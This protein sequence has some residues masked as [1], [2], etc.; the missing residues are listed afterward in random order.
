MP[1][2][3][4]GSGSCSADWSTVSVRQT[5]IRARISSITS[6]PGPSLCWIFRLD[7]VTHQTLQPLSHLPCHHQENL[8]RRT[9]KRL[10]VLSHPH[11]RRNGGGHRGRMITTHQH[12]HLTHQRA[13]STDH[14]NG[15]TGPSHRQRTTLEHEQHPRALPLPN[16]HITRFDLAQRQPLRQRQQLPHL[17]QRTNPART[18]APRS[19]PPITVDGES[20][21]KRGLV[22]EKDRRLLSVVVESTSLLQ[23]GVHASVTPVDGGQCALEMLHAHAAA[24]PHGVSGGDAEWRV[25]GGGEDIYGH[26]VGVE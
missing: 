11:G 13:R 25:N 16:Q 22:A 24:R 4:C 10:P 7:H 26:G 12:R 19:S 8:R 14:R 18:R 15:D 2:H 23:I 5:E 1:Y 21:E 9:Q 3:C 17:P 6:N 20:G